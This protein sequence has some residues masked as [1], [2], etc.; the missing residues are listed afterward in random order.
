VDDE[1]KCCNKCGE[2]KPLDEF[3]KA[4]GTK[5]GHRGECIACAKVIRHEWYDAN[6]RQGC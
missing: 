6:P 5:D 3:Y 1:T 4:A 2:L